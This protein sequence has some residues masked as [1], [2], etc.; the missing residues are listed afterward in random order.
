MF[1]LTPLSKKVYI[2]MAIIAFVASFI[3]LV[4]FSHSLSII[5]GII[6]GTLISILRFW[7]LE[8]SI[9][10][11]IT[12]T[13][14]KAKVYAS[15]QAGLRLTLTIFALFVAIQQH[16]FINFFGVIFGLINMQISAYISGL[17]ISK[18]K[19]D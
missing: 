15:T 9:T 14:N 1:K 16:P 8:R 18:K 13:I 4:F 3:A 12:M 10:K 7:L 5:Y 19:A 2:T 11:S 6:V 17:V